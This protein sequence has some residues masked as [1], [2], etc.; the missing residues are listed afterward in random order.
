M[1]Q[2]WSGSSRC[3]VPRKFLP[4]KYDY[5]RP[6]PAAILPGGSQC[7]APII[8]A[9]TAQGGSGSGSNDGSTSS[10]SSGSG[11]SQP[12]QPL[13][14]RSGS[15]ASSVAARHAGSSGNTASGGRSLQI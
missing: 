1:W 5:H 13:V 3:F 14:S 4:P 8:K 6:A 9:G 12:Q 10:G 15:G 2:Y 7:D 11:A